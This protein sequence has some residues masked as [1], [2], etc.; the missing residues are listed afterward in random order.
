LAEIAARE[1]LPVEILRMDVDSDESVRQ[2]IGGIT[3]PI[4][5]LVNNAGIEVHG[6][7]EELAMESIIA[8]MNTNYFGTVRCVK[9]VVKQ[10][11]E[12]GSGCIINVSSVSGRISCSPLGAYAASKHAV[13]AIS[14]QLAGELKAFGVRVA[15]VEPGIQD[16]DMARSIGVGEGSI[17]PHLRRLGGMFRAALSQPTPP[18]ATAEVIR[19]IIESGTWQ[20]RHLSGPDA[21]PF[22]GWRQSMNDEQWVDWSAQDDESW[23]AAVERDFGMNARG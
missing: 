6:S 20:L 16:T 12:R 15:I 18:S 11:R 23:Y 22:V 5:V 9:A 13:E 10:M 14:E 1:K 17:Y 8:V 4:D 7:V 2:T 21:A 3:D 19:T